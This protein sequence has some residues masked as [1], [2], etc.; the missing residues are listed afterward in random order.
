MKTRGGSPCILNLCSQGKGHELY[1]HLS[2]YQCGE[3]FD[4]V[5]SGDYLDGVMCIDLQDIPFE[6]NYFDFIITEDV[7]EHV[8][9]ITRALKEIN[10]VLKSGGKYI[11][12]VP[13]HENIVTMSRK[14]N[15][16]EVFHGDPLHPEGQRFLQILA[17]I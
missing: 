4:G 2:G 10:H 3:Y 13:V 9:D 14:N 6:D 15:P 5:A 11:F 8:W 12:T 17:W 7:L 16:L 1:R